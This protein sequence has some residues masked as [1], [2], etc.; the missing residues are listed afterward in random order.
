[1]VLPCLPY[2]PQMVRWLASTMS[3]T[4]CSHNPWWGLRPTLK[5]L[6]ILGPHTLMGLECRATRIYDYFEQIC[7]V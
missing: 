4:R 5:A 3:Q 2:G 1:M 6:A 7:V